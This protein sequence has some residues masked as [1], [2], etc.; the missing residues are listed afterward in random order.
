MMMVKM[1]VMDGDDV[2]ILL[3]TTTGFEDGL[4][5]TKLVE[6]FAVV[7]VISAQFQKPCRN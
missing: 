4:V 6:V 2:G 3:T 7:I 1:V 5:V